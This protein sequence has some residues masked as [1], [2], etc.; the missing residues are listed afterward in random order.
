MIYDSRS[1]LKDLMIYLGKRVLHCAG[2]KEGIA[3]SCRGIDNF[4]EN[5]EKTCVPLN[6]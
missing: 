5:S 1:R 4:H 6:R 3:M 2:N